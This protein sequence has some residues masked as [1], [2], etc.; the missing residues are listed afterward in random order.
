MD[1]A[2]LGECRRLFTISR[3][4]AERL[5][6]FNGLAAS[7]STRRRRCSAAT[8]R[9]AYGDFLLCAGRLDAPEAPRARDPRARARGP[10][11]RG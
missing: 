4:V 10:R 11:R 5:A 8:A 6:R 9:D 7:R 2:A 3:N 1:A